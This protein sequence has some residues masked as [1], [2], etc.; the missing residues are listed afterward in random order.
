MESYY[1]YEIAPTGYAGALLGDK[2]TL[3]STLPGKLLHNIISHGIARIAEFLTT[4]SPT[5]IAYG[6]ASPLLR[7]MGEDGN[8][9]R[10]AGHHRENDR[11]TAYFTFSSQMKPSLHHFR[12]YGSKN[13]LI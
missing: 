13:G 6:F 4:D 11:T 8:Y 5:V 3:G 10:A 7:G 9:R 2:A 1:G 12:I